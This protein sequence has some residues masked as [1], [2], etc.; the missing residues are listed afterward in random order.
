MKFVMSVLVH[1]KFGVISLS[2]FSLFFQ[3]LFYHNFNQ[4]RVGFWG[5]ATAYLH[6]LGTLSRA[7]KQVCQPLVRRA[8]ILIKI[9]AI[10]IAI[11][12]PKLGP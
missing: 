3:R 2:F 6:N 8:I 5:L 7:P 10:I 4:F 1:A 11:I 9:I 12:V